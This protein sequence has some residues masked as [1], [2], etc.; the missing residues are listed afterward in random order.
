MVNID[1]HNYAKKKAKEENY[2]SSVFDDEITEYMS[3]IMFEL[4]LKKAEDGRKAFNAYTVILMSG[5]LLSVTSSTDEALGIVNAMREKI[6]R[7][8]NTLNEE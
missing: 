1:L 4:E 6:I 2:D 5:I 3:R 7:V 8:D